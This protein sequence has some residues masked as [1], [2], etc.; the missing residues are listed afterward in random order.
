METKQITYFV[1][2]HRDVT[3]EEFKEHY[4]PALSRAA[5]NPNARFVIGDYYG[6]D[7]M[8][9]KYLKE[10]GIKNVVVFHMLEKPRNNAGFP[11]IGGFTS[12]EDRDSAMTDVSD[13]DILWV[14]P[15]KEGSGTDQNR[16]RRLY[17]NNTYMDECRISNHSI[18]KR[19]R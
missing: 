1:S 17:P 15:G 5:W 11:T 4:A 12:D 16:L 14:R 3:E 10:E 2:G 19:G 13:E 7:I 6:V 8:A 18:V 9:Q